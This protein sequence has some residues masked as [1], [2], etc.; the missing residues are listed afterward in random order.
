MNVEDLTEK[1][2]HYTLLKFNQEEKEN[3]LQIVRQGS[4]QALT[5]VSR[6]LEIL[7]R[8]ESE[9]IEAR[10]LKGPVLAQSLYGDVSQRQMRDLDILVGQGDMIRTLEVLQ[11]MGYKLK[12]PDRSLSARQWRR[13]FLSGCRY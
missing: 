11:L 7:D 8:F 3:W 5:F 2:I 4:I 9:G 6:L 13:Y 12:F 1:D 10:P